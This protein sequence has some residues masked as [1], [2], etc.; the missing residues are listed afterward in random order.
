MYELSR[1]LSFSH[2]PTYSWNNGF[3]I[4]SE[5][6]VSISPEKQPWKSLERCLCRGIHSSKRVVQ[7]KLLLELNLP[8][9]LPG[10][11]PFLLLQPSYYSLSQNLGFL[12]PFHQ[13]AS[14]LSLLR[15]QSS[16]QSP[17]QIHRGCGTHHSPEHWIISLG[18]NWLLSLFIHSPFLSESAQPFSMVWGELLP[19]SMGFL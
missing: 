1:T 2:I 6:L 12:S 4:S 3:R 17:S 8:C 16:C 10:S 7:E 18:W 15:Y 9:L 19:D 14:F 11:L 13:K 5:Q